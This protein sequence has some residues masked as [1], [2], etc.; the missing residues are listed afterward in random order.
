[1][2]Y[3]VSVSQEPE[4]EMLDESLGTLGAGTWNSTLEA[5][6]AGAFSLASEEPPPVPPSSPPFVFFSAPPSAVF[7][8]SSSLPDE[9][10]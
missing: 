2:A 4:V 3:T 6:S 1:M 8:L 7:F 9:E 10:A 5:V